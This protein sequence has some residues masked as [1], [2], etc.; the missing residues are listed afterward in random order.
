MWGNR[1]CIV[2][3]PPDDKMHRAAISIVGMGAALTDTLRPLLNAPQ[4]CIVDQLRRTAKG[5]YYVQISTPLSAQARA[6]MALKIS[7]QGT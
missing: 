7:D 1:W 6:F 2:M 5:G 3:D 4:G